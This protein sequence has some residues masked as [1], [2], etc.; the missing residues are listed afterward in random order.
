MHCMYRAAVKHCNWYFFL[1]CAHQSKF[2]VWVHFSLVFDDDCWRQLEKGQQH[3][4]IFQQ[5]MRR[6]KI[7]LHRTRTNHDYF[8]LS[9]D[10]LYDYDGFETPSEKVCLIS[11]IKLHTHSLS[12]THDNIRRQR[13]FSANER[14]TNFFRVWGIQS[15]CCFFFIRHFRQGCCAC[16]FRPWSLSTYFSWSHDFMNGNQLESWNFLGY[17][18]LYRMCFMWKSRYR[19]ADLLDSFARYSLQKQETRS[20]KRKKCVSVELG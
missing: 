2:R 5:T 20:I 16:N 12:M 1:L 7:V 9:A 19:T 18:Y 15:C 14:K 13:E 4:L 6:M 11:A 3:L 17:V 8:L 10:S